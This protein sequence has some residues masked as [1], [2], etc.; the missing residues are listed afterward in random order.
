MAKDEQF[1]P[2]FHAA[3][4]RED[5]RPPLD[6]F[7]QSLAALDADACIGAY[8]AA[9]TDPAYHYAR[10][11]KISLGVF[12]ALA[13]VAVDRGTPLYAVRFDALVQAEKT[14]WHER[15]SL[16]QSGQRKKLTTRSAQKQKALPKTQREAVRMLP[17]VVRTGRSGDLERYVDGLTFRDAHECLLAYI[18]ASLRYPPD[19]ARSLQ[20]FMGLSVLTIRKGDADFVKQYRGLVSKPGTTWSLRW[21]A[22]EKFYRDRI[23][24]ELRSRPL[25]VQMI[26]AGREKGSVPVPVVTPAPGNLRDDATRRDAALPTGTTR[27]FVALFDAYM[28]PG[29]DPKAKKHALTEF[30]FAQKLPGARECLAAYLD[31]SARYPDDSE[32][33]LY[34]FWGIASRLINV[35]KAYEALKLDTLRATPGTVVAKRFAALHETF[36]TKLQG[37]ITTLIRLRNRRILD[38][39]RF[40]YWKR[41]RADADLASL[42]RFEADSDPSHR[43]A[44]RGAARDCDRTFN[45]R[46][47][48]AFSTAFDAYVNL[49]HA[50]TDPLVLVTMLKWCR[51]LGELSPVLRAELYWYGVLA[52]QI[53]ALVRYPEVY[54]RGLSDE[55]KEFFLHPSLVPQGYRF[56]FDRRMEFVFWKR[57]RG[58]DKPAEPGAPAK[59]KPAAPSLRDVA[60]AHVM[61]LFL[62]QK[63]GFSLVAMD[64][65]QRIRDKLYALKA[66]KSKSLADITIPVNSR[67]PK[68]H[69]TLGATVGDVY[70]VWFERKTSRVY[71]EMDGCGQVLFEADSYL[72]LGRLKRDDETYGQIWRDTKHLLVVIGLFYRIMGYLPDLVSGGFAML[73]TAVVTD[74]MVEA[75]AEQA[76]LGEKETLALSIAAQ[77]LTGRMVE[78]AYQSRGS[79][80][81]L[82]LDD[83][84]ELFRD[85]SRGTSHPW[86]L[87]VAPRDRG[88]GEI[89]KVLDTS[90]S[91]GSRGATKGTQ[92]LDDLHGEPHLTGGGRDV[93]HQHRA[94]GEEPG[95]PKPRSED[96]TGSV[97]DDRQE[98]GAA[99][100]K[101]ADPDEYDRFQGDERA[102]PVGGTTDSRA[103][104]NT[105]VK[106]RSGAKGGKGGGPSRAP[107]YDIIRDESH[108]VVQDLIAEGWQFKKVPLKQPKSFGGAF[109]RS[110]GADFEWRVTSPSGV[111][112]D[113]DFLARD[114]RTS[115]SLLMVD[116]KATRVTDP[117]RSGHIVFWSD[118]AESLGRATALSLES[119]GRLTVDIVCNINEVVGKT[120]RP[121]TQPPTFSVVGP[122]A[123]HNVVQQQLAVELMERQGKVLADFYKARGKPGYKPTRDEVQRLVDRRVEVS[124]VE[125]GKIHPT[126]EPPGKGPK[127]P[128]SKK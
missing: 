60:R 85:I 30:I 118:K 18:E 22:L 40:E 87:P 49:M 31:A 75:F 113:A 51:E 10:A 76:R 24:E 65:A 86:N 63:L 89:S 120:V 25:K 33:S 23:E 105:A 7:I 107:H 109:H 9:S 41:H 106:P 13:M 42:R 99:R 15:F 100:K 108:P 101:R 72:K 104:R 103:T 78:G 61:L 32:P 121:P 95:G 112:F 17:E 90:S 47:A 59:A 64:E 79:R 50:Q 35:G 68:D 122:E 119:E 58:T 28:A 66:D 110:F 14:P 46:D 84:D 81:L 73:V 62:A 80:V 1:V 83:V 70:I 115:G 124:D 98:Y 116:A 43:D 16:L 4:R 111:H 56:D 123:Y 92:A 54:D 114:P 97:H 11:D 20:V 6:A 117:D 36:R 27:R 91:G 67:F 128:G 52:L 26:E 88:T 44:L 77:M 38:D 127:G 94:G 57:A 55:E 126:K 3:M 2:L 93:P 8:F 102:Q 21:G 71:L 69:L 96:E 82:D 29:G 37:E 5:A 39:L 48:Q 12:A 53:A 34:I 125:W 19:N 74:V 45:R